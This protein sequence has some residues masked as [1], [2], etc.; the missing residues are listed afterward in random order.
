[1]GPVAHRV[2]AGRRL[3][4]AAGFAGACAATVGA[5]LVGCVAVDEP[6]VPDHL[7]ID[8]PVPVAAG[9]D[10][11]VV[12]FYWFGCPHCADMHPRL[13]AWHARQGSDVRFRTE[14]AILRESWQAGARLH[15]TLLALGVLDRLAGSVF[16]A[17]QGDLLDLGD[18]AQVATWAAMAGLDREPFLRQYRS[19]EISARVHQSADATRRHGV[20][21]V[22]ALVVD[23]RRLTSNGLSG[24]PAETLAVLDRLVAQARRERRATR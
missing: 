20:R 4:L 17:V 6:P 7:L 18:E 13:S 10:V 12:E 9:P 24:G 2:W 22:P 1:M 15:H 8:P 21:G 23:G 19:A 5:G 3:W 11:E 14:P 16:E